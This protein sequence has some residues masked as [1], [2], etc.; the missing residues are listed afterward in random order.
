MRKELGQAAGH[1][2]DEA[3]LRALAHPIRWALIEA[4][5]VAGTATAARCAEILGESHAS[6]SFH[7]RQL[8][9]FGLV[10]QAPTTS[11]RDRPWRLTSV[12]QSWSAGPTEDAARDRA[13]GDLTRVFVH[14][15]TER[16][17]RWVGDEVTA[18]AEWRRAAFHTGVLTWM[19]PDELDEVSD[20]VSA[21]MQRYVERIDT[22]ENR[23]AGARPVRLF[24][25]GFPVLELD[26]DAE[27]ADVGGD[28][29]AT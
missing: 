15:E 18:P 9:R 28:V 27:D 13:A 20:A 29:R 25:V 5:S 2:A 11:R 21:L 22:P 16:I 7:L 6:C 8:A 24:S 4:L 1:L 14:R 26:P 3:S 12:R 17:R 19:T 10:E 23:P